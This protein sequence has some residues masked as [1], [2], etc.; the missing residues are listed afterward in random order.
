MR[1]RRRASSDPRSCSRPRPARSTKS[2][3]RPDR[4][5]AP[6]ACSWRRSCCAQARARCRRDRT[7]RPSE[8]ICWRCAFQ[9]GDPAL[10][11]LA[12][13][14]EVDTAARAAQRLGEEEVLVAVVAFEV[15]LA[16]LIGMLD[17]AQLGFDGRQAVARLARAAAF[18]HEALLEL[19]ADGV[20]G[21]P[22]DGRGALQR[23]L[24]GIGGAAGRRL[25]GRGLRPAAA[26]A[27]RGTRAR[28]ESARA[29][30]RNCSTA[31]S[32]APTP[33]TRPAS[34]RPQWPRRGHAAGHVLYAFSICPAVAHSKGQQSLCRAG[35]EGD[36]GHQQL[37][38]QCG[39]IGA[40]CR[41]MSR[42]TNAATIAAALDDASR[43]CA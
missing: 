23:W 20:L 31:T 16:L 10:C 22:V 32:P 26:A 5:A 11:L 39:A 12:L 24:L 38:G 43:S 36:Y 4:S 19:Q 25:H 9:L 30:S 18:L 17:L 37:G 7:A 40:M 27:A 1:L 6:P 42:K 21:R 34:R 2:R 28:R 8:T 14:G 29:R 35:C 13:L 3:R 15:G 33:G 41:A